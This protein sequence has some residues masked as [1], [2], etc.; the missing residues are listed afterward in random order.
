MEGVTLL[1]NS[2]SSFPTGHV[3]VLFSVE[4]RDELAQVRFW[5]SHLTYDLF[6]DD[7][8]VL[9]QYQERWN[10]WMR[11]LISNRRAS[12]RQPDILDGRSMKK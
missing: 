1:L 8:E 2:P 6:R 5:T 11:L 12:P 7:P 9:A 4:D 10:A 3:P